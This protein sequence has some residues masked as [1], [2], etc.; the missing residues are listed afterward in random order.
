MCGFLFSDMLSYIG[1]VAA[2]VLGR[3]L[4][5]VGSVQEEPER[6]VLLVPGKK[7]K[8]GRF[9]YLGEAYVLPPPMSLWFIQ[10]SFQFL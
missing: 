9:S 4:G 2:G 1:G 8:S 7:R 3:G 5:F 6:A 10:V